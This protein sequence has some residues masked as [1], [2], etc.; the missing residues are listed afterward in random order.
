MKFE[1]TEV[2]NFEGA[3]RGMRNP[4]ES[5]R[6]SD[7][8]FGLI[9]PECDF[10]EQDVAD[11]W[12]EKENNERI[13]QG[14][15]PWS[16]DAENYYDYDNVLDN[17]CAW[18]L[19]NG[20]LREYNFIRDVAYLGPNDL[21]LAQKLIIAGS[22]HYKFMR[23]IFVS[24]DITAPLYWW[25]EFDTYKVGTTANS[26][27]TMHKL[28]STPIT[29]DCFEIDDYESNLIFLEGIDNNGDYCHDY[30][31][32][33]KDIVETEGCNTYNEPTIIQFLEELRLKYI[34]TKDKRYWKELIRWLP[35]SWLQTRTV[36]M[37]YANLRNIYF[38]RR[39]H[40][41]TEWH[42]FCDWIKSL[43]Y[44][45]ELITLEE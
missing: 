2:F 42:S 37:T 28:V 30:Q 3:F 20:T 25:K 32:A 9:N 16:I 14:K 4:L 1:N 17:Y 18:L 10:S 39:Y 45:K 24:V 44:A 23:Q 33:I 40:K 12:L 43:P 21:E 27:S 7:S 15:E 6:F 5:W 34:E 22:E 19:D 29:L 31:V 35:E 11:E 36:T 38:Q 26:T 8:F 13:E 41:L